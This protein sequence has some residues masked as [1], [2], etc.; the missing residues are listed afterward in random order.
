[1]SLIM[2]SLL[3]DSCLAQSSACAETPPTCTQ[4]FS[5]SPPTPPRKRVSARM[6][7]TAHCRVALAFTCSP[8]PAQLLADLVLH[9]LVPAAPRACSSRR[10]PRAPRRRT[11]C[12]PLV[13]FRRPFT[14]GRAHAKT[15]AGSCRLQP[16]LFGPAGAFAGRHWADNPLPRRPR[17][18]C[19]RSARFLGGRL[20]LRAHIQC[21]LSSPHVQSHLTRCRGSN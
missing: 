18:I 21:C 20:E 6:E 13:V 9:F 7:W 17:R 8:F 19:R 2:T 11:Q 15:T 10:L 16:R 14:R 5:R 1:M 4:H 12:C 3:S